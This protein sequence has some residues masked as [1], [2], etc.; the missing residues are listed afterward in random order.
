MRC[1][2]KGAEVFAASYGF[3]HRKGDLLV[4]GIAYNSGVARSP[5][6]HQ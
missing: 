2:P 3:K 6:N 5:G 4:W 1:L